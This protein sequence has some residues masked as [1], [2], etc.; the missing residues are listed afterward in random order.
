M[1]SLVVFTIVFSG[2]MYVLLW[3]E[4]YKGNMEVEYDF[5]KNQVLWG[6][7]T[8]TFSYILY[9]WKKR[10]VEKGLVKPHS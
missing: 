5:I 7:G 6:I 1:K 4:I 2:S 9:L 8:P 10:D 3:I